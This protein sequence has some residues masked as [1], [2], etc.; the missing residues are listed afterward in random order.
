MGRGLSVIPL[1][2]HL[3]DSISWNESQ[4]AWELTEYI[5]N[6]VTFTRCQEDFE[7]TKF[8]IDLNT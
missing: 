1:P 2:A 4:P 5:F 6:G 8:K 7:M 3:W